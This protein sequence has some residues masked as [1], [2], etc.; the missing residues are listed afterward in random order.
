MTIL[1]TLGTLIVVVLAAITIATFVAALAA[2]VLVTGAVH[3][4]E[5]RRTLTGPAPGRF[6]QLARTLLTVPEPRTEILV[7]DA[8]LQR[9]PAWY[10]RGTKWVSR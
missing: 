2:T 8:V 9:E 1:D 10:D 4:E 7:P 3:T 6:T 5:R